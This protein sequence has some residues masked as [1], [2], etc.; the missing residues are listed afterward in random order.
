MHLIILAFYEYTDK[1][2]ISNPL[3]PS[4][5]RCSKNTQPLCTCLIW[6]LVQIKVS[7]KSNKSITLVIFMLQ[8]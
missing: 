5:Y 3:S 6:I 2:E 4:V 7:Y 8:W 1:I